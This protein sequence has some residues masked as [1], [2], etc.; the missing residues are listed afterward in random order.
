[1][2]ELPNYANAYTLRGQIKKQRNDPD[3]AMAEV[4]S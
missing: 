1:V 3:G 2:P 4:E